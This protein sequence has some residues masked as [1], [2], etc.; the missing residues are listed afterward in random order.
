MDNGEANFIVLSLRDLHLPCAEGRQ[1]KPERLGSLLA[2]FVAP[3]REL[4]TPSARFLV[5]PRLE[6][7][8]WC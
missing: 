8:L 5:I 4:L 1:E 2:N 3:Q 6:C 7:R